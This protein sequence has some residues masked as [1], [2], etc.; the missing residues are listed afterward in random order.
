MFPNLIAFLKMTSIHHSESDPLT[1][2]V[3]FPSGK[4]AGP[5]G[6]GCE[7]YKRFHE[8][9]LPLMWRMANDSI[10]N[11]KLPNSLHVANVCLLLK[12]RREKT[13]PASYRP[14]ALLNF[15]QKVIAK[16]LATRLG[17]H[18]STIIHHDRTGFIPDRFSCSNVCLLLSTIY[19]THD[20]DAK[21]VVLSFDAQKAFL[22]DRMA[23][24][25]LY[26]ER[27]RIWGELHRMG[28]SNWFR[29]SFIYSY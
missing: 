19:S 24:Y 12:K 14:I 4:A 29:N 5:D 23:I 26:T 3:A 10:K 7:F 9:I 25:V 28:Q 17:N 6:F 13:N 27:I 8:K 22:S 11:K 15:D 2:T 21:I 18:F 1:A 20:K 16:V